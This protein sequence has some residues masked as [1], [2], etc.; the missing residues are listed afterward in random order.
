MGG[1]VACIWIDYLEALIIT[2]NNHN[3]STMILKSSLLITSILW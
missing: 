2:L 1:Q 3:F